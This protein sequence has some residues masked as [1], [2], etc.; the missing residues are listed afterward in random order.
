MRTAEHGVCGAALD[1][2]T[3]EVQAL[4]VAVEAPVPLQ[5]DVAAPFAGK[6]KSDRARLAFVPYHL[7]ESSRRGRGKMDQLE[8]RACIELRAAVSKNPLPPGA[9]ELAAT[10]TAEAG[11]QQVQSI[12]SRIG[13]SADKDDVVHQ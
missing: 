2:I 8:K 9:E 4:V 7:H 13:L 6:P 12:V 3:D 1:R 5:R 11:E 10:C